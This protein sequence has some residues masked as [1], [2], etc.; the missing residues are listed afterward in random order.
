[1]NAAVDVVDNVSKF[2]FDGLSGSII[3]SLIA[4][5]IVFAVLAGLS[6]MIYATRYFAMIAGKKKTAEKTAPSVV[7]PVP[8]AAPVSRA[9]DV[10][11][12]KRVVAVISAAVHAS[13]GGSVNIISVTPAK[14]N[15]SD[16][17]KMWRAT[18][19]AEC[20]ASRFGT[21]TGSGSR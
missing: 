4:F 17:N 1:M 3:V 5:S 14:G 13:A 2:S 15:C 20:M 19:I 9:P 16:M 21:G 6:A 8:A 12:M 10:K 11:D 7:E 18:G